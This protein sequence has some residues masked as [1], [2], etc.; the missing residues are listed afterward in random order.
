MM[1]RFISFDMRHVS[2]IVEFKAACRRSARVR[3]HPRLLTSSADDIVYHFMRLLKQRL[4]RAVKAAQRCLR[5][6]TDDS[7][8]HTG[9][10]THVSF[11]RDVVK[12]DVSR[13]ERL[14]LICEDGCFHARSTGCGAQTS[15]SFF[16][17][18]RK[19]FAPTVRPTFYGRKTAADVDFHLPAPLFFC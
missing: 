13:Y 10:S 7:W 3:I 14:R 16:D 12:Y 15:S 5:G 17:R 9:I 1:A 18:S 11:A 19:T 8:T 2:L 6:G 4:S